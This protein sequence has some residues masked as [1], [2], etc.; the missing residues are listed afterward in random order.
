MTVLAPVLEIFDGHNPNPK[1][2]NVSQKSKQSTLAARSDFSITSLSFL[3]SS[4][5]NLLAT[6]SEVETVIKLWDLRQ[7]QI[8]ARKKGHSQLPVAATEEPRSHEIHRKFGINSLA[9]NTDRSRLFALS[10]DHTVYAYSTSH[11]ILGTTP[12]MTPSTN[13]SRKSL[14]PM[15]TES[16]TGLGPLYALRHPSLRVATFWPRLSIRKCDRSN[17]E[18]LAVASTDDCTI[19]F[20]TSEK[21][22]T[23]ST[24]TIPSLH[25]PATKTSSSSSANSSATGPHNDTVPTSRPSIRRSATS[26]F[27]SL[28][29]RERQEEDNLPIY[30]HGT[31]LVNGH[32]KEVTSVVWSSEGNLVTASDDF[33]VRCWRESAG[34]GRRMRDLS[35]KKDAASLLRSGWADVGVVGWDEED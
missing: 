30:Y 16:A 18:L 11:L 20:P 27:T 7:S 26:S 2:K 5:S 17:S 8:S 29:T 31:P 22:Q 10:R 21:Y 35:R 34:E 15:R 24:R 13:A 23:A 25:D 33:N 14:A 6:A 12:E 4:R 32:R 1:N 3:D 19:L 9:M 28:F